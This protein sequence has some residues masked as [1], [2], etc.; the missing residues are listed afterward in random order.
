MNAFVYMFMM[1][2]QCG[3][4]TPPQKKNN[5][6]K[7]LEEPKSGKKNTQIM[8]QHKWK[9]LTCSG[10]SGL[11]RLMLPKAKPETQSLV[12]SHLTLNA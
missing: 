6:K 7:L 12:S 9:T 3:V 8:R 11:E 1:A 10:L 5:P 4:S 2:T